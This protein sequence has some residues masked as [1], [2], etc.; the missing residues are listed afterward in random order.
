MC[1]D[2]P[3][4]AVVDMVD[5][6]VC[7]AQER[8]RWAQ[9]Y[10][11][12]HRFQRIRQFPEGISPPRRVRVYRRNDHFILQWWD[13]ASHHN[14]AERIDGD[15]LAALVRARQ[16]DDRLRDRHEAGSGRRRLTHDQLIEGFLD[17]LRQRADAAHVQPA[18]VR[19]YQAALQHFQQFV[20]D[21]AIRRRYP[22][23]ATLNR[24][25]RLAFEAHVAATPVTGRAP[26]SRRLPKG[27]AMIADVV[28]A[29]LAWAADPER[30]G[31][32]PDYFRNPFLHRSEPR[33]IA[34]ADPLAEP[35]IDLAMALDLVRSCD[36]W[37]LRLFAPMLLFGLRASEPCYLFHEYLQD[38]WLRVPC[39]P[40]LGY[41]TKGGRDKRFPLVPELEPLWGLLHRNE[42]VG[43]LYQRRHVSEGR[44]RAPWGNVSLAELTAEF[45]KRC[46][47][48]RARTA[49]HR[50]QIRDAL[51][52]DAGGLTYDQVEREFGALARRLNWPSAATLKDLRHLFATTLGNTA[53]PEAYRRYLMGHAPGK[54]A[55]MAY[56]HL[57]RLREHYRQAVGG[58]WAPLVDAIRERLGEIK[59]S[60]LPGSG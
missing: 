5:G 45:G 43:L 18:T 14:L 29:M 33:R 11:S 21:P 13:R 46:A 19:R 6:A 47:T 8:S 51:L 58:E 4:T 2:S 16:I 25:F 32:L 9:Q 56:T 20:D 52:R 28:R 31:L 39:N 10:G 3:R 49:F 12:K 27:Q 7:R 44:Q 59:S 17:D 37:Q 36:R 26:G 50:Q 24:D 1:S 38:G 23:P 57:N 15:L 30:G 40:D 35:D 54:A 48:A 42:D 53:M 41:Q 60:G 55:V 34:A 22:H